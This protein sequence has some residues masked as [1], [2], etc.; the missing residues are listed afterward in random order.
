MI[1][2]GKGKIEV[3]LHGPIAGEVVEFLCNYAVFLDNEMYT[4]N[5][6]D[7]GDGWVSVEFERE[8]MEILLSGFGEISELAVKICDYLYEKGERGEFI[9]E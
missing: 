1:E 3:E 9:A 4:R 8:T 6:E 2:K 7:K 5:A